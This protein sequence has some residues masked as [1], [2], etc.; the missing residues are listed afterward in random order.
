MMEQATGWGDTQVGKVLARKLSQNGHWAKCLEAVFLL[1]LFFLFCLSV[2]IKLSTVV[3]ACNSSM[4]TQT[5]ESSWG[6]LST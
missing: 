5:Q 3:R 2:V 6:T 1:P 4:G